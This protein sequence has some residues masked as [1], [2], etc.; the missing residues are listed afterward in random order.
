[1]GP[2][3]EGEKSEELPLEENTSW[4]KY[5]FRSYGGCRIILGAVLALALTL[6]PNPA[7]AQT[8]SRAN[9]SGDET[10]VQGRMGKRYAK[11]SGV[12][13]T[14]T[15]KVMPPGDERFLM[16]TLSPPRPFDRL[17]RFT[18]PLTIV[19]PLSAPRSIRSEPDNLT[20][21]TLTQARYY[22]CDP[23]GRGG[24][25]QTGH[26]TECSEFGQNGNHY[27]T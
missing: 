4:R 14:P 24:S 3:L 6:S 9:P 21:R 19:S 8:G 5:L 13:E 18:S 10:L 2:H 16:A 22:L 27:V 25:L 7:Q 1:M 15:T 20:D 17:P 12:S 11:S 26:T 23:Y